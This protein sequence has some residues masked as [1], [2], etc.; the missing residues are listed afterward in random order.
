LHEVTE[1][2]RE[3]MPE[4]EDYEDVASAIFRRSEGN[5]KSVWFQL[6]LISSR[7]EDQEELP[8]SYEDV[9]LSLVPSD[10]AVL[11]FVVFTIGGLTIAH[12]ASLLQATDLHL[13]PDVVSNS[14]A[15]LAA[16]GLLV[17]N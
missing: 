7:R 17:V 10:Q 5:L 12:L 15:D 14:I 6:R 2:V 8:A 13:H 9:I 3:V 16:L 1:L 11:R 4:A